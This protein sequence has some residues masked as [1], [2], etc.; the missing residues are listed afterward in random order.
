[1]NWTEAYKPERKAEWADIA[2]AIRDAVS[3]DEALAMYCPN[4]PRRN[5]R[6]PCPIH[7]GTDYN[8][9]Y[10]KTGYK[11][12]VC[13]ASGDV[14]ALVKEV[15]ELSTRADAMKQINS[16]FN[17]NLPINC[18]LDEVHCAEM[19]KRRAEAEA[20]QKRISAWWDQY[21]ALLDEWITLDRTR[22]ESAPMSDEY[23]KAVKRID[24]V[25]Y[26]IDNL[27]IEPR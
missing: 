27:P 19:A 25:A 16:D 3:M 11:C 6:C 1:M 18:A 13:G 12:F 4:T 9:S 20:K 15:C 24:Y 5:H 2:Q 22:R 26:Q 17:L 10:T 23:A 21:H 8:F 14:V 7:M